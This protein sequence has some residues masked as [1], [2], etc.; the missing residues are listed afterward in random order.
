MPSKYAMA[1]AEA[2][3]PHIE[4]HKEGAEAVVAAIACRAALVVSLASLIDQHF[5]PLVEAMKRARLVVADRASGGRMITRKGDAGVYLHSLDQ[6]LA[7]AG[8]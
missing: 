8:A 2:W 6:A 4:P 3:T 5:K 1:A 7:D